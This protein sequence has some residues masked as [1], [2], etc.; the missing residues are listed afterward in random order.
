MT[1][2]PGSVPPPPGSAGEAGTAVSDPG[3]A[4]LVAAMESAPAA[5]YCLAA[6]GGEPVWA[7]ARA[8]SLGLDPGALPVVDGRPVADVV[9]TVLR[10]GRTE[11]VCG[12]MGSD[13]PSAT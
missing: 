7:N 10:T 4:V 5:I 2:S 12:P 3:A 6:A 13:G 9:D 8:R 1:I 11:T